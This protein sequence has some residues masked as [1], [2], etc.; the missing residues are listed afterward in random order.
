MLGAIIGDICGSIYEFNNC[1]DYDSID[2]FSERSIFTDD[3]VMTIAVAHAL[4]DMRSGET[5]DFY[6]AESAVTELVKH[7]MLYYGRLFPGAGYGSKFMKWLS[8][9]TPEPYN[10]YGNGSGMRVSSVGWLANDLDSVMRMAERT[11]LPTH[12]HRDGMIGASVIEGCILLARQHVDKSFIHNFAASYYDMSFS[13]DEIRPTYHFDETCQGSVP[14]AIKAFLESKDFEDCLRLAISIG[15]DSDTIACMA[16]GIAEAYYGG[17]PAEFLSLA[18]DRLP[19]CLWSQV[20][21]F[22]DITKV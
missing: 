22:L 6:D 10:S 17:V 2:L 19:E 9:R 12:N 15:G 3:T 14:Q 1:K 4:M 7:S 8:L 20:E 5:E 11:A 18:K 13:L 21:R 16:G